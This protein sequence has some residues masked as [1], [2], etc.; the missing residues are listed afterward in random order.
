MRSY[1]VVAAA[2]GASLIAACSGTEP[3]APPPPLDQV[4]TYKLSTIIGKPLPA[5]VMHQLNDNFRRV[6]TSG[7]LSLTP[8]DDYTV[9]VS[10][11]DEDE[12]SGR[13]ID[14][15][16]DVERG[17]YTRAADSLRF[18]DEVEQARD[19]TSLGAFGPVILREGQ[20]E[21][22]KVDADVYFLVASF[23]KE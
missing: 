13:M 12:L 14:S 5:V 15:G 9:Q 2:L 20:L 8:S 7:Q 1:T 11:R 22:P 23:E 19:T 3:S 18:L 17:R 16:T 21:L 6:I 4:G 10:W